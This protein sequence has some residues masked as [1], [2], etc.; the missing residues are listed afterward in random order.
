MRARQFSDLLTDGEAYIY[1][2]YVCGSAMYQLG[3]AAHP[4]DIIVYRLRLLVVDKPNLH[5][6]IFAVSREPAGE[7]A[8]DGVR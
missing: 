7:W 4:S 8:S 5:N 3:P 6:K 2:M 1:C